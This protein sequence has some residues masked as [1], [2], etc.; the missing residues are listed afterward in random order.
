MRIVLGHDAA[1]GRYAADRLGIPIEPPFTSMGVVD[2]ISNELIGAIIYNRYNRFDIEIS[3]YAPR[4]MNRRFIR[5]AFAYP[6][7][8]L[9]V[10]RLTAR[11]KRTGLRLT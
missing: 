6:F 7:E 11:T 2:D 9:G 8:Q 1:V 4:A 10:L 5:A 3:V